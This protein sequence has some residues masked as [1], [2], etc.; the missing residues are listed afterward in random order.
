MK[1]KVTILKINIDK[2]SKLSTK[3][4]IQ[5]IPTLILFKNGQI[6]WRQSGVVP[7]NQM[8]QIILSNCK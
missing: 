7:V 3:Y 6:Q 2:N 4:E 1:E 8:Q 5:S